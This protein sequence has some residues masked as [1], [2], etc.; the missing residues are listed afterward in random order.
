MLKNLAIRQSR[1]KDLAA[2]ESLYPAAF[3]DEDLVP[4]VRELLN[5]PEVAN[6]LVGIIGKQRVGH[7]IF[8]KCGI[9][10]KDC[11]VA[12]LGPLAVAPS[13]QRQGIG[14]AIVRAGLTALESNGVSRV[15]VLGDPLYYRRLGFLPDSLIEPPFPLPPAYDGAWQS[16]GLGEF[17]R[18]VSGKLCVPSQ[19]RKRSLWVP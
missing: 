5:D 4:L 7:A 16:R 9:D 19:W 18:P 14:S 1:Q 11:C 6:S 13:W 15:C 8:T 2:I 17:S 12:L 3:P 10:G